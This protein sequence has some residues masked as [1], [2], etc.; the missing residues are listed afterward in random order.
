MKTVKLT[1]KQTSTA[2]FEYLQKRGKNPNR[3]RGVA[4]EDEQGVWDGYDVLKFSVNVK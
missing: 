4:V 3:K 1:K 2:I